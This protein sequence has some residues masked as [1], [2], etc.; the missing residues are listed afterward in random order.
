MRRALAA[1]VL[2][3][4]LPTAHAQDKANSQFTH[5]GEFRVRDS[6]MMNSAGVK[7]SDTNKAYGRFKL[8]I[9]AKA[10]DKLSANLTV[11]HNSTF[12]YNGSTNLPDGTAGT[13]DYLTV[14][15]A[16]GSWVAS[17]DLT[18]KV[19]R[20]NYQI[21]DG[22]IMGLNDWEN[23]PYAYEGIMGN[24]E[25]EFGRFQVFAF[26]FDEKAVT[27]GMGGSNPED[28]LYGVNFDLKTMPEVL[29][30][31]NVHVLQNNADAT[32]ASTGTSQMRYGLNANL[33]FGIIDLGLWYEG[34][35][36]KDVSTAGV[37]N[38]HAGSLMAAAVGANF[39][40]F[41]NSKVWV[42]YH[43]D[44]GDKTGNGNTK[45]EGYSSFYTEK[46]ASAGHM[47]ILGFGNLTFIQVGWTGK[48]ADNTEV[49]LNYWMFSKTEKTSGATAGLNQG[50]TAEAADKTKLGDEI[51]LW[52]SHKYDSGLTTT[53]RLGMF[54][55]GD[56]YKDAAT[57]QDKTVTEVFLEGRYS[58]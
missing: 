44:T 37:K 4:M 28:N 50:F 34:H 55:P 56:V 14:N 57:K 19:G 39:A 49:G 40:N 20:M 5:S 46:H 7:D 13:E 51:D 1:A 21:G 9:G 52:A 12:G 33:A 16:F 42:K 6:W 3:A 25:A 48:P 11:M 30:G 18:I 2:L 29:K 36:G 23:V 54:M 32:T 41:M 53:L 27:A 24:W 26:K 15:Q 8:D 47:D 31:L 10:G 45:N 38:D 43:Q 35:T 17:D 22:T 58:F